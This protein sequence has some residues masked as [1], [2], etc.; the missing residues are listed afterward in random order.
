MEN[1][2]VLQDKGQTPPG[3]RRKR[4]AVITIIIILL[5]I[6]ITLIACWQ[7]GLFDQYEGP[8]VVGSLKEGQLPGTDALKEAE[9]DQVRIQINAEP[10]FAD[11]ES[12]G[13]LY[14]GNPDTNMYDMVVEITL[15]DTGEI[16]FQSGRIP[17]GYYI[18]S[19][20]LQTILSAGEYSATASIIYYNGE[21]V[22]V[23]YSIKQKITI[24]N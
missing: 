12:E 14:I 10:V 7:M 6:T 8:Q 4:K 24:Q 22:Q 23:S 21:E 15:D 1:I 17:P 3:N 2:G 11:G 20:K 18:D 19:D 9:D 5:L 16:A 13:N